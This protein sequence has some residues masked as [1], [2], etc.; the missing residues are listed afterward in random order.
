MGA[1]TAPA[2]NPERF[3]ADLLDG[4]PQAVM[5]TDIEGHITYWNAAAEHLYGW[6]R[7][8]V[9]GRPISEVTPSDLSRDQA[10][11]ILELLRAGQSWSGEFSVRRKDG[12]VFIAD[13]HDSPL[14]DD[15]GHVVGFIGVSRDA[16]PRLR[17][18]RHDRFQADLLAAVGQAVV[19]TDLDGT[20]TF[21]NPAAERLYGWP[22]EEVVGRPLETVLG[23]HQTLEAVEDGWS[24]GTTSAHYWTERRDGRKVLVRL[25]TSPLLDAG[26][27]LIGFIAVGADITAEQATQ[28]RYRDIVENAPV[29]ILRTTPRG[30]LEYVN[31]AAVAMF[32]YADTDEML[33]RVPQVLALYEDLADRARLLRESQKATPAPVVTRMRRADGRS[34]W[35]EIRARRHRGPDGQDRLEGTV[36]DL[37]A[38][39]DQQ[40]LNE[41]L[42][43]IVESA[44]AAI[45]STDT[46]G[47]ILTWNRGAVQILG[48][49][50]E[51][52]TGQVMCDLIIDDAERTS[53]RHAVQAA[54]RAEVPVR[55][56]HVKGRNKDGDTLALS[57]SAAPLHD[58]NG[59]TIGLSLVVHDMTVHQKAEEARR[60]NERLIEVDQRLR[61]FVN[62]AAHDLGQ[63]LTPMKIGMATLQRNPEAV[64]PSARNTLA[65]ISRNVDRMNLLVQDLLDVA[66][67]ES[68]S[69]KFDIQEVDVT[70]VLNET[71]AFFREQATEAG[72]R[73][74]ADITHDLHVAAD[75]RRL[76]QVLF[77]YVVNAM[78]FTPKDGTITLR[79]LQNGE[80]ARLEVQDTG[81]GLTQPQIQ[82]LFRAFSQVH[83]A[84]PDAPKGTGLGL[85]ISKGLVEKQH[86]SVGVTSPGSGKGSTFW[87]ELPLVAQE[88][89]SPAMAD[90]RTG[91]VRGSNRG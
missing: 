70:H 76:I 4:V 56:L 72:I 48:Y 9:L 14:I 46:D 88:A 29:G 43:A 91:N 63:P 36:H 50:T 90:N 45:I 26:G 57:V 64:A 42:A 52:A 11:R 66:R 8:E 68:G 60:E 85:Y 69:I 3:E 54:M 80:H 51:H 5:A 16:E 71:L 74:A 53:F 75:H 20:I 38:Q 33:R 21:W 73:L 6:R 32:G 77:N 67:I 55:S 31:P 7:D 87:L 12:S 27:T 79:C 22:C 25:S 47:R 84:G 18:Q 61:E 13:V 82:G 23:K 65:L 28:Q 34:M 39:R 19:A 17:A 83:E 49:S 24:P 30:R 2:G 58:A 59:T 78:K 62:A 1:A 86:G 35:V 40:E 37:T 41:R 81:A 89:P 44:E 10:Q 15:L